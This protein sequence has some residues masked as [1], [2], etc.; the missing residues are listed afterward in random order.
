M[1]RNNMIYHGYSPLFEGGG[2]K[3]YIDALLNHQSFKVSNCVITT[4]KNIEQKQIKLLHF[5]ST[6]LLAEFSEKC[7]AVFSLHDHNL[8]C[9]SGAKYLITN[10][11]CCPRQLSYLGCIWG[12]LVEGCGSRRPQKILRNLQQSYWKLETL[13]K[14][15]IMVIANSH[16]VRKQLLANGFPAERVV[17]LHLGIPQPSIASKPLSLKTHQQQKILFVGRIVPNKG[18]DWLLKA[19][20]IAPPN[21]HLDIAGDGWGRT[22][23]EK[24]AN[25]LGVSN[26][27]SWHGWCSREKLDKLYQQCF[28]LIF[29]SVWPEPAGLVTLEAYAHHRPVI[30]SAVGGIPEYLRDGET[31]ILVPA[32][33]IKKLASAIGNLATDY[34]KSRKLGEQSYLRF[35]QNYTLDLHIKHLQTLY[36][37]VI[38]NFHRELNKVI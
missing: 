36:E 33:D 16:Y 24:L 37:Q 2:T 28:A 23:M 14:R 7:P 3:T 18:L 30:A 32:H 21:I 10:Q 15:K 19:L 29:P 38:D 17:T 4:L 35:L 22:V 34:S 31:G 20:A 5:H 12:H 9:P 1:L 8:Y 13:K 26:R 6:D 11:S 25:Q 27:L